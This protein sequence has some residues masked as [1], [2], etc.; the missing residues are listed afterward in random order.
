MGEVDMIFVAIDPR[1]YEIHLT[2]NCWHNHILVQHPIMKGRLSNV[3]N[4]I[5]KP[6]FI[7]QSKYKA[8]SHLYFSKTSIAHGVEYALVVVTIRQRTRKGYIQ[9]AFI[10]DSLSKGG[11][12][13]W[14]KP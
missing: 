7:Y 9:T 11:K 13:L 1:G 2:N 14:K 8:S 10:V 12:L 6:D 5:V 4:A 3:K